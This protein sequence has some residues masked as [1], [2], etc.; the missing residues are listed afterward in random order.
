M[1]IP[2]GMAAQLGWVA[3]STYG[4]AVTVTKFLPFRSESITDEYQRSEADDIIAGAQVMRSEQHRLSNK[5]FSGGVSMY[6]FNRNVQSLFLMALGSNVTAGAGPYTH[7]VTPGDLTGDMM[8]LQVGRPDN[9]GTVRAFS[10][11]GVK[12]QSLKLAQTQGELATMDLEV[13]AEDVATGTALATASYPAS[14]ARYHSNDLAVSVAASAVCARSFEI[15]FANSFDDTRRCVGSTIIKEPLRNDLMTIS[16][17]MELE[18]STLDMYNR[19]V[20]MTEA[21]LVATW[22][23]G[24]NSIAI[25]LNAEFTP[26]TQPVAGRGVV[27]Q[28]VGFKAVGA[29]TDAGACTVVVTNADTTI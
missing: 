5:A 19:D 12:V 10:Y 27:Y 8:S 4:T 17:S 14:L 2:T 23:N 21:A 7:T 29:S 25:T 20:N 18:W 6:L 28:T 1:A 15:E 24:A 22:T 16:G 26:V 13:I 11:E 3:E 9:G